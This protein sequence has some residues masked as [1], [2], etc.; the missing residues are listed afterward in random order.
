MAKGG[1]GRAAQAF[2]A[3]KRP[4]RPFARPAPHQAKGD[5][6]C[7]QFIIA[8][9][10]A[11]RLGALCLGR[12]QGA[13]SLGKARPGFALQQR[14]IHP[15]RHIRQGFQRPIQRIGHVPPGKPGRQRPHW[16]PKR[17]AERR[18]H[19][20]VSIQFQLPGALIGLEPPGHAPFRPLREG[21]RQRRARPSGAGE[22]DQR[23][24]IG[25]ANRRYRPRPTSPACWGAGN[26]QFQRYFLPLNRARQPAQHGPMLHAFG[27]VQ[28]QIQHPATACGARQ[29][30]RLAQP[31][32][33]FNGRQ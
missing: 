17:D 31:G 11:R 19:Q 15:F 12:V 22:G 8:K 24:R 6:P 14:A 4:A 26:A 21:A 23:H 29:Q 7:Q 30:F 10:P 20:R 5:L 2:I 9:P 18:F 32:Q 1:Q 27:Q 33:A 25:A 3:H 13:Q 28:Q 16:L